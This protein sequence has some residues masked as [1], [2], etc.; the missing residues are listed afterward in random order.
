MV[1]DRFEFD[2]PAPAE[3]VFD[4][5]HYHHWRGRWDSLVNAGGLHPCGIAPRPRAGR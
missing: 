1:H 2:M 4:A 5:F 3:V